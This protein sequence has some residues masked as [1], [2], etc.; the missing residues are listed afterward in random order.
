MWPLSHYPNERNE[1]FQKSHPEWNTVLRIK[2]VVLPVLSRWRQSLESSSKHFSF[3]LPSNRTWE[4]KN[5][6][7]EIPREIQS[8]IWKGWKFAEALTKFVARFNSNACK[9]TLHEGC[10]T[11]FKFPD[12]LPWYC[13]PQRHQRKDFTTFHTLQGELHSHL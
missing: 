9:P 4:G 2:R 8:W 1:I 12:A 10:R 13:W 11:M 6:R 5:I 7:D 3:T